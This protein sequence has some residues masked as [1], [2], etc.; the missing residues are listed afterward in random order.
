M[1]TR[2]SMFLEMGKE[3][4]HWPDPKIKKIIKFVIFMSAWNPICLKLQYCFSENYKV[5]YFIL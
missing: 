3:D 1:G 2:V 5:M 4:P